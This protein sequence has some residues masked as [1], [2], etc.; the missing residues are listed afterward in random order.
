MASPTQHTVVR[1]AAKPTCAVRFAWRPPS[2]TLRAFALQE[3]RE[4]A[5]DVFEQLCHA[6]NDDDPRSHVPDSFYE[7]H[8][9]DIVTH[10]LSACIM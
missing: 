10:F 2:H 8:Q 3:V 6:Q 1:S 7:F 5:K 9:M 4:A